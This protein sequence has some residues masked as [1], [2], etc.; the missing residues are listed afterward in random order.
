MPVKI[1]IAV[2][3]YGGL[4]KNDCAQS[5]CR[6]TYALLK[7]G[8]E[9][10]VVIGNQ[11]FIEWSRNHFAT[12]CLDGDYTHLGFVDND[13]TF[14]PRCFGALLKADKSVI[15]SDYAKRDLGRGSVTKYFSPP[16]PIENGTTEV[17]A[18]GLGLCLIKTAALR[19]MRDSGK[20]TKYDRHPVED[21]NRPIF[22]FFDRPIESGEDV[23]FCVRFREIVGEPVHALLTE[24]IGHVGFM[25]F[26]AEH[27]R[28]TKV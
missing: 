5:L 25:T 21:Y 2:P 23:A 9:N 13:M 16:R 28:L 4:I 1:L 18:I 12:A 26:R 10:R 19:V 11:H 7:D 15:G 17:F 6:L 22:G 14:E 3:S 20:L 27:A 8:I 24:D